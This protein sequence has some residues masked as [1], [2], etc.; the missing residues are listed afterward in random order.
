MK[1][2][3]AILF[4]SLLTAA[5][6]AAG[7]TVPALSRIVRYNSVFN[8]FASGIYG[9]PAMQ[10]HRHG[11]TLT[12]IDITGRY[13]TQREAVRI[14]TGKA[15]IAGDV[16]ASAFIDKAKV[17]LWG[18]A[19][20]EYGKKYGLNFNE[21]SDYDIVYPYVTGDSV[22]GNLPTQTYR[23]TGG[24]ARSIGRFAIGGEASYRA[25]IEYRQVDPRPMNIVS[26]FDLSIGAAAPAGGRY[27]AAL[28]LCAGKYKQTNRLKFFNEMGVPNVLHFTGL[29]TDYYRFRGSH[30]DNYYNGYNVG[31]SLS[32]NSNGRKGW[33]MHIGYGWFTFEKIISSLNEL[34]MAEVGEHTVTAEA[35][36][37]AR[38]DR[39]WAILFD[40]QFLHRTGTE[41][42]FGD[43]ADN[44]YPQI[45]SAQQY[46]DTRIRAVIRALYG[47]RKDDH[48]EWSV[49]PSVGYLSESENYTYPSRRMRLS[50]ACASV[51]GRFSYSWSKWAISINGRG[52][53]LADTGSSLSLPSSATLWDTPHITLFRYLGSHYGIAHAN[54]ILRFSPSAACALSLKADYTAVIFN[55]HNV[56]RAAL[57]S[58][59]VA[60]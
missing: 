15:L 45:A 60:F 3:V 43:A 17:S 32:L 20:Y 57:L 11:Y 8:G 14:Q 53:I 30:Y 58:L 41:N 47:I 27:T 22:G 36:Y 4:S 5:V 59:G 21:T 55:S 18:S 1:Y 51:S 48:W 23:F 13:R 54:A 56:T 2:L 10:L 49:S 19:G 44:I 26:D 31:G 12:Q 38:G 37:I 16:T 6:A 50:H 40:G 39:F 25:C 24:F 28:S 52:V 35:G 46:A 33:R 29:G 42:I 9:N 34:P 7:D